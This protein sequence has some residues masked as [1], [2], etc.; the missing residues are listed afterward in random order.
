MKAA[1]YL[2]VSREEQVEKFGLE[3][4]RDQCE[5]MAKAKGWEVAA[6]FS[7]E[8]L[9]GTL[10]VTERPGLLALVRAAEAGLIDAVIVAALDRLG[11]QTRIVLG[12]AELLASMNVEL[13]SCRESLDTSTPAGEFV[14]TMFAGLAQLEKDT[15]RQRTIAG[16]AKSVES[17]NIQTAG[18]V[19]PYGYDVEARNGSRTLVINDSETAIVQHL[20][21]EYA[22]GKVTINGLA[23]WLTRRGVPKPSKGNCH[24]ATTTRKRW[25]VGTVASIL[26]NEVYVGRWYYRKTRRERQPDGSIKRVRRPRSEWLM[27][28]VPAIIDEDTFQAVQRR[29][30]ENRQQIAGRRKHYYTLSGMLKCGHCGMSITGVTRY[31]KTKSGQRA[32]QYYLC[33]RRHSPG[34]YSGERCSLPPATAQEIDATIWNWVSDA[35]TL[36]DK[37]RKEWEKHRQQTLDEL[38]PLAGLLDVN[39]KKIEALQAEKERLVR[40]YA[41]GALTLDDIAAQKTDIE[42]TIEEYRRAS[43]GLRA[44]LSQRM[45][46]EAE[47]EKIEEF[48]E[49]LGL[50]VEEAAEVPE[51][52]H[53]LYR[54]LQMK[55]VV[56]YENGEHW[57][58]FSCILGKARL[59][60]ASCK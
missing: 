1:I 28:E 6:T 9:S 17:G 2:R 36:P 13:I 10:D 29:R 18:S 51:L 5:A 15:I 11:R 14:L 21:R 12:V 23:Q 45:P 4:Q 47:F 19:A 24:R 16:M 3:V 31:G 60:T 46:S 33:R 53:E 37:L 56:T 8:G 38:Q 52:R 32:Y 50:G 20:F 42:R 58:D 30:K 26:S 41:Q 48:V 59:S 43:E 35:M 40:A 7:D 34:S 49:E 44:D 22:A 25:S 54:R 27:V 55:A 57:V 39:E